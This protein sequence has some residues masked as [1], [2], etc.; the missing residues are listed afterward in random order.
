MLIVAL[1]LVRT[2][3]QAK[4]LLHLSG[5]R[6]Y[7]RADRHGME[8]INRSAGSYGIRRQATLPC[9]RHLPPLLAFL[10]QV[11]HVLHLAYLFC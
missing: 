4:L 6:V 3:W 2:G 9:R 8:F 7:I 5:Y 10:L 1:V 11:C